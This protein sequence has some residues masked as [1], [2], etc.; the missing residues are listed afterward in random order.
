MKPLPAFVAP[1]NRTPDFTAETVPAALI[2]DHTTKAG[3]RGV[4]TV[5]FGPHLF[6]VVGEHQ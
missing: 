5:A 1:Y 4:I 2:R 6:Y 3:V